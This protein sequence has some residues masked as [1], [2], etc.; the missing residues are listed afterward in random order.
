MDHLMCRLLIA[1]VAFV[2]GMFYQ[3]RPGNS[4]LM[5]YAYNLPWMILALAL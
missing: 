5:S 2:S 1:A 4:L 3:A